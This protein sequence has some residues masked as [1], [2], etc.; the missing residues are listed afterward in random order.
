MPYRSIETILYP[1]WVV[2]CYIYILIALDALVD[3]IVPKE[4]LASIVPIPKA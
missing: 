2:L 4:R 1:I 3:L